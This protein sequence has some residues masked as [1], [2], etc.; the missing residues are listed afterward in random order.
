MPVYDDWICIAA[1]KNS[2]YLPF[3]P[4]MN[5]LETGSCWLL[6]EALSHRL[7]CAARHADR[8]QG[9]ARL[10]AWVKECGVVKASSHLQA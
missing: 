9:L 10:K 5:F 7:L 8:N 3:K 4:P 1:N 6:V 2:S